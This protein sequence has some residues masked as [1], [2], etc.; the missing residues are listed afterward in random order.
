MANVRST[1]KQAP[2]PLGDKIAAA[3]AI[4]GVETPEAPKLGPLGNAD[5]IE[6]GSTEHAH[7]LLIDPK[8]GRPLVSTAGL[9]RRHVREFTRSRRAAFKAGMPS[10]PVGCP[11][12]WNPDAESERV[13]G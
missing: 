5:Y 9:S 3:K 4:G 6:H 8:T 11:S 7:M 1:K 13:G 12:A 2:I 10:A